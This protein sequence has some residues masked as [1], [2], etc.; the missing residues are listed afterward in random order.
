MADFKIQKINANVVQ[1]ADKIQNHGPV[2]HQFQV[3]PRVKAQLQDL[4]ED[5]AALTQSGA[6]SH[7]VGQELRNS[8]LTATDEANAPAPRRRR[9]IAALSHAKEIAVGL[10]AAA[11]IAESVDAVVR[12]LGGAA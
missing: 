8:I 9:L 6:V 5:L 10:T 2:I 1:N 7:E 12:T 4:L 11:G 3:T